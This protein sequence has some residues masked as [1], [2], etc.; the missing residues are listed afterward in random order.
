MRLGF[1]EHRKPG[2][3]F[4]HNLASRKLIYGLAFIGVSGEIVQLR[5]LTAGAFHFLDVQE[6]LLTFRICISVCHKYLLWTIDGLIESLQ[7][8]CSDVN[9]E[10]F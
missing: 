4:D 1:L 6:V 5:D 2:V 9:W 8:L 7:G 3:Q 10:F